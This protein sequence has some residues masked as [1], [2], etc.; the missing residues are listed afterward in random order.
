MPNSWKR[1]ESCLD[2]RHPMIQK[3]EK[4]VY[5]LVLKDSNLE[6]K[7]V[8]ADKLKEQQNITHKIGDAFFFI[9]EKQNLRREKVVV[10][11]T[12]GEAFAHAIQQLTACHA[13]LKSLNISIEG[14]IVS[15]KVPASVIIDREY[16]KLQ[17]LYQGHVKRRSQQMTETFVS[18][19]KSTVE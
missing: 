6:S 13:M 16:Q 5:R 7:K 19:D 18:F 8:N 12:K 11:E 15:S 4:A 1:F 3:G 2:T 10:V 9:S 17:K 14:R